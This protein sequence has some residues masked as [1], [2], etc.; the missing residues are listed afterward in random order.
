[1]AENLVFNELNKKDSEIYYWKSQKQEEVDFVIKK[2]QK[3][4]QAIQVCWHIEKSETKKREVG[5]LAKA[6]KELKLKE[7]LIL[8]EDT[9]S[10]E[11]INGIK[12]SFEPIWKWLL[13]R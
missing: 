12:I 4:M 10:N 5:V 7:G 3:I 11:T 8:T 1:M 13:E 6:C 9:L 2:K